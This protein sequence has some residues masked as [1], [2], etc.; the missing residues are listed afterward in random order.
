MHAIRNW[1]YVGKYHETLDRQYLSV[2]AIDAMLQLE[3]AVK[4]PGIVSL[5]L[6]VDDGVPLSAK[7]LQQGIGFVLTEKQQGHTVL[8]A[9]GAGISRSAAFAVAAL[10]ETERLSLL[11]ALRSVK[12]QH[13]E[14]LP[15][16]A[17]WESLCAYYHETVSVQALL[18][19]IHNTPSC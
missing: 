2:Y 17:L 4:H 7:L 3:D 8:I 10:K 15:H 14:A 18:D 9:C 12:A 5:Y 6:P 11:E 13:P 1:L 16:P 19:I